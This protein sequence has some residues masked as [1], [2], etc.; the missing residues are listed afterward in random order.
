VSK[1]KTTDRNRKDI[2][3]LISAISLGV[4]LVATVVLYIILGVFS[5]FTQIGFILT[6]AGIIAS[7]VF[8]RGALITFFKRSGSITGIYK[9]VQF[10][11]IFAVVVFVYL[12]SDA[13]KWKLDLTSTRLYSFSQETTDVLSSLTNDL[14]IKLFKPSQRTAHPVIDYQENLLRR[15]EASSRHI[16][17][18]MIDPVQNPVLA[19]DYG[20]KENGIAVFIYDNNQYHVRINEIYEIDQRTGDMSYKG[21]AAYTSAIKSLLYHMTKNVYVLKGHGEIQPADKTSFGFSG[22][23]E[24]LQQEFVKITPLDLLQFTRVPED[25]GALVIGNP[26][27]PFTVD[28]LK[29]IKDYLNDGGNVMVMLEFNT[30]FLINDILKNMGLFYRPNLIV[31]EENFIPQL[32][33]AVFVPRMVQH[34]DITLP[35]LRSQLNIVLHTAAGIDRLPV[36]EK[37]DRYRYSIR[38]L[39]RTSDHAYGETSA[40]E[41]RSGSVTKDAKDIPGPLDVAFA[42]RREEERIITNVRGEV[43]TNIIE[44][45]MVTIGDTDFVNNINYDRYAN[46][47]FF[48]NSMNFLLK[49]EEMVTVRPKTSAIQEFALSSVGKRVL[50]ILCFSIFVIYLGVGIVIVVRRRSIVKE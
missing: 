50:T 6:G 49:R 16:T 23:F 10:I 19:E 18:E 29:K 15:Y 45:R 40:D 17:L 32:G 13:V 28:E 11:V 36:E 38:T 42:V 5:I 26:S 34:P 4:F 7:I 3:K 41:I 43:E 24:R 9:A 8:N 14:E 20:I 27:R 31:E 39:L 30:H 21:E 22:I 46:A 33:K 1:N 2:A 48:L 25:A 37:P 35:I 44:A 47:D 12:I